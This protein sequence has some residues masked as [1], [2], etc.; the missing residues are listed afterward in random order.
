MRDEKV[1]AVV[2]RSRSQT[3]QNTSV[4]QHFW[5]LRCGKCAWLRREAHLDVKPFWKLRCSKSARLCGTK[6]ISKSKCQ[7]RLMLQARLWCEAHSEVKSVKNWLSRAI[8]G[9]RMLKICR[10]LWCETHFEAKCKTP[11]VPIFRCWSV[12]SPGRRNGFCTLPKKRNV[13]GFEACAKTMAGVG[14]LK[15]ICKHV[16]RAAG[17]VQ[18][19]L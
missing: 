13:K 12:I 19:T 16:F 2:T 6:H 3:A 11:H 5:K 7:S 10:A 8:F 17:A 14:R 4:S 9:S 15:R 1:H 18:K